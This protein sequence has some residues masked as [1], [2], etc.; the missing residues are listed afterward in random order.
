MRDLIRTP[1]S[2]SCLPPE[3]GNSPGD[4]EDPLVQG[5]HEDQEIPMREVTL[6]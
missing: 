2:D 4:Q 1:K 3:S 6:K 5:L